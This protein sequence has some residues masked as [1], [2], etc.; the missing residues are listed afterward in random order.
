M[1]RQPTA[2]SQDFQD[3]IEAVDVATPATYVRLANLYKGSWEGFAP[4]PKALA[5]RINKT[6]P[7]LK[8]FAI[9]GQWTSAGGGICSAVISGKE[10]AEIA[11]KAL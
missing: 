1:H 7:G 10:A 8:N 4:T 5:T 11:E 9:C 2:V 6:V 3:A